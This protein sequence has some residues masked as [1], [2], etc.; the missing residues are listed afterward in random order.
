MSVC[1]E[2]NSLK[3]AVE[4][5]ILLASS[6]SSSPTKFT[7]GHLPIYLYWRKADRQAIHAEISLLQCPGC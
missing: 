2:L 5:I 7:R 3:S 1:I 4:L 6:Q